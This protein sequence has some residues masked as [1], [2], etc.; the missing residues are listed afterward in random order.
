[1]GCGQDEERGG[2]ERKKIV[3]IRKVAKMEQI[4]G[5]RDRKY[6]KAYRLKAVVLLLVCLFTFGLSADLEAKVVKGVIGRGE[7]AVVGVT[8]EEG[9]LIAL[10]RARADAITQAVGVKIQSAVLVKNTVLVADFL[11]TFSR[12]FIVEEK[13][14]WLPLADLRENE[15]QPPIPLFRVEIEAIVGV[16]ERKLDPG[17]LLRAELDKKIFQAGDQARLSATVTRKAHLAI[18]NLMAN[19]RVTMIYPNPKEAKTR[20]LLPGETFSF[21]PAGDI[22]QMTT[23]PGHQRDCEAFMVTAVME[24][25]DRL[26][27]FTDYFTYGQEYLVPQFFEMYCRFADAAQEEI[28]PYEVQSK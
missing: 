25:E 4:L 27:C 24:R 9:R 6:L 7:A 28:I 1:L 17:F 21:P 3:R 11:K 10:Q 15:H 2:D 23:L 22:L 19:D 26:F 8:A 18:F 12:G 16:P 14:K 13:V 5:T 20:L